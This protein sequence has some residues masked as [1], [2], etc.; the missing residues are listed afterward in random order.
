MV[1]KPRLLGRKRKTSSKR[2]PSKKAP[3]TRNSKQTK[4]TAQKSTKKIEDNTNTSIEHY[5]MDIN[6]CAKVT[7][8]ECQKEITKSPKIVIDSPIK[9]S[10]AEPTE[11]LSS[12]DRT[13]RN[14]FLKYP[15]QV[16]CVYCFAMKLKTKK[17][18]PLKNYYVLDKMDFPMFTEDWSLRDELRLLSN[19][20]KLGLDNWEDIAKA[21]SNKGKVEC[22]SHYYTFYYKS[23]N[24]KMP[25]K[26][27]VIIQNAPY[28]KDYDYEF[29]EELDARNRKKENVLKENIIHNQGKIPEFTTSANG[30]HV[31]NRSRSLIKN[32]HKKK[33]EENA[34]MTS[35]SEI[36]G[37]W[38]KREEFDIEY[39]NDAELELS[40]LEFHDD[41]TKEERNAKMKIL[42]IYNRELDERAK[43]K[44]FVIERNLFDIKKQ[45][46][47]ERKLSKEDR[48]I[49]NCLKPFARFVKNEQFHELFE[50]FVL[51]KNLKLRLNQLNYYKSIGCNT[52]ED[53]QRT[54]EEE[55]KKNTYSNNK[56]NVSSNSSSTGEQ[57][58]KFLRNNSNADERE[59]EKDFIKSVGVKKPIYNEL[60]NKIKKDVLNEKSSK[61][62]INASILKKYKINKKT[63]DKIIDYVIECQ[64]FQNNK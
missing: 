23:K 40:E 43:R 4:S 52:Y 34:M 53:I 51:E 8:F 35:A 31:L 10:E 11:I 44:Q 16:I 59:A 56:E 19:M 14:P 60:K 2:K 39:L 54:I 37:Y 6:G 5:A 20:E 17:S 36:L 38:P 22:E 12:R 55:A 32:R 41:D 62:L 18:H 3:R 58:T 21:M 57:V 26:N 48:D 27:D 24:D 29:D 61:D 45:I 30:T 49:Y 25:S 33:N 13:K 9:S 46:A 7:C 64:T 50:G 15:Y 28:N 63:L 1:S 42:Q 47:F